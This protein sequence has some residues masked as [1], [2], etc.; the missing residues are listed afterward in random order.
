MHKSRPKNF[1]P[2]STG[3]RS[4]LPPRSARRWPISLTGLWALGTRVA[5][6][7][8]CLAARFILYLASHTRLGLSQHSQFAQSGNVLLADNHVLPNAGDGTGRLDG[9]Y[10]RARVHRRRS[11]LWRVAGVGRCRLLLDKYIANPA[12]LGRLRSDPSSWRR[13]WRFSGQAARRGRAGP[14]SLFSIC[15]TIRLH[16]DQHFVVQTQSCQ[17]GALNCRYSLEEKCGYCWSK[18][19][20]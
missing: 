20:P 5:R 10:S 4:S 7:C 15:G 17:N 16:F 8:F 18:T 1:I 19:T 3:Q 6:P 14:E 12:F 2:C 13:G 9:G 11:R